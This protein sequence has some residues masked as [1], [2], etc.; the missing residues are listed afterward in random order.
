MNGNEQYF[1]PRL[2]LALLSLAIVMLL[3]FVV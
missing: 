2:A 1:Y 3:L